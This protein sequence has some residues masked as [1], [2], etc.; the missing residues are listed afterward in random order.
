MKNDGLNPSISVC[1]I[2]GAEI[3]IARYSCD[4]KSICE[5]CSDIIKNHGTMLIEVSDK[6]TDDKM[7]RTGFVLGI[8]AEAVKRLFKNY[9][10][11]A[12]ITKTELKLA[13]GENLYNQMKIGGKNYEESDHEKR[14]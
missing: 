8:K 2:C 5:T 13:L 14:A 4:G 1:S 12:Y 3:G 6:S 11:V 9:V 10:P 7:F